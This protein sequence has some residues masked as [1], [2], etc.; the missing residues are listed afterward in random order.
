MKLKHNESEKTKI[1]IT[2]NPDSNNVGIFLTNPEA[3]D[4]ERLG[5]LCG[6][7]DMELKNMIIC[8]KMTLP[9]AVSYIEHAV[10][11]AV[12]A[13]IKDYAFCA[14]NTA[15]KESDPRQQKS[16]SMTSRS[17]EVMKK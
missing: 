8:Q 1:I 16:P 14:M 17:C 5:M 2:C 13:F 4:G 6:H 9:E 12:E 10:Q 15:H 3:T 11:T 7:I